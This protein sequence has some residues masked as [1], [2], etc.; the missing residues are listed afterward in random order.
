MIK[1]KDY[2]LKGKFK[3]LVVTYKRNQRAACGRGLGI[4]VLCFFTGAD[5]E[6][7]VGSQREGLF[8]VS[9]LTLALNSRMAL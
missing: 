7:G 5:V 1:N 2:N 6:G 3:F 9:S 4:L 8:G